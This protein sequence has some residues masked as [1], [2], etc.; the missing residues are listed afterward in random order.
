MWD[1]WWGE[2]LSKGAVF[3]LRPAGWGE[4]SDVKSRGL[5]A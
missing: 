5:D 1:V 4:T 3:E 2:L